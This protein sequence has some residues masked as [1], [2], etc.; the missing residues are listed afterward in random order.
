MN[1][2]YRVH[3]SEIMKSILLSLGKSQK[4]LSEEMSM[5][6]TV[7]SNILHG[8][9]T[10]TK[11]IAAAFEKATGYPAE[12]LLKAQIDYDSYYSITDNVSVEKSYKVNAEYELPNSSYLL[13]I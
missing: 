6:K 12:S 1:K 8:K 5:N 2:N 9:R 10:I 7:I 3:P 13:A 4:W 11:K